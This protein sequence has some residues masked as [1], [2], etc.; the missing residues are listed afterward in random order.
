MLPIINNNIKPYL[1]TFMKK[2]EGKMKP[3]SVALMSKINS[4]SCF[5]NR[6]CGI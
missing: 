2:Y 1:L 4:C 3:Y 6:R 5:S